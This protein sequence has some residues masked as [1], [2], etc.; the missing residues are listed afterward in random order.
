ME[1]IL[2]SVSGGR[3]SALMAKIMLENYPAENLIFAF[4]NTGKELEATLQF[5]NEMD[6]QWGLNMVWIE[7]CTI[8]KFKVVSFQT[9]SR[10]GEPFEALIKKRKYLPNR[11]TRFC[12]GDLKVKPIN[13]FMQ[14]LGFSSW[15]TAIGIR[16]DEPRRYHKMKASEGKNRWDYIFPLWDFNITKAKVF[17]FW[18]NQHF[19]LGIHSNLGNCDFCFLK[20]REKKINQFRLM[21][22]NIEWW[23]KMEQI[24]GSRFHNDFTFEQLKTMASQPELFDDTIECFCGD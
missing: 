2:V 23:I 5:V 19:D 20:G 9:A 10:N 22:E 18:G 14:S 7:Y 21:P 24:T 4:A 3:S 15:D 17:E 16:R 13:Y 8:N 6:L 12:T 11:V 1:P